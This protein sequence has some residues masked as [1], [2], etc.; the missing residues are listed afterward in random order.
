MISNVIFK[1]FFFQREKETFQLLREHLF[2]K[3][4]TKNS[5]KHLFYIFI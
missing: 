1:D 2:F 5:P 4:K 3:I